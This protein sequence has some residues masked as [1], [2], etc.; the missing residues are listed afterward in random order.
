MD[1]ADDLR[2][3]GGLVVPGAALRWSFTHAQG[4]G[5]QHVNKTATRVTLEAD[6]D[7][8][9]GGAAALAR[10]RAADTATW[11]VSSQAS[12]SQWRNRLTCRERLAEVLDAAARPPAAPR[13]PSRPTR[14]S[15]ERRL[16]AKR[17][18]GEKK[19]GRRGSSS[20]EW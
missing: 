11:R 6:T 15:V 10:L 16:S 13:R 9:Q 7:A 18:T 2:T 1:D 8:V 3:P 5:G 17:R 20:S 12:R 14:G 4:A 19:L